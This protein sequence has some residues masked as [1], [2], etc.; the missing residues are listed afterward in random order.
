MRIKTLTVGL[1]ATLFLGVPALGGDLDPATEAA[2][3]PEA[4]FALCDALATRYAEACLQW[5][6]STESVRYLKSARGDDPWCVIH[7]VPCAPSPADPLQ[8][9]TTTATLYRVEGSAEHDLAALCADINCNPVDVCAAAPTLCDIAG[10]AISLDYQDP[11]PLALHGPA[12]ADIDH[13]G[14]IDGVAIKDATG[15]LY[16]DTTCRGYTLGINCVTTATAE[17]RPLGSYVKEATCTPSGEDYW[18]DHCSKFHGHTERITT[19][20]VSTTIPAS[21]PACSVNDPVGCANAYVGMVTGL[22]RTTTRDATVYVYE[23][24]GELDGAEMHDDLCQVKCVHPF[25][26]LQE[27][28]EAVPERYVP[29]LDCT[30][31]IIASTIYMP[32]PGWHAEATVGLVDLDNDGWSDGIGVYDAI[33]HQEVWTLGTDSISPGIGDAIISAIDTPAPSWHFLPT[34]CLKIHPENFE[35]RINWSCSFSIP[36]A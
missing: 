26:L 22:H 6:A 5:Q 3:S 8:Y 13:D 27:A 18:V 36:A 4:R 23:S 17:A 2:T 1:L 11:F 21:A 15:W 35:V 32:P 30:L 33:R 20:G 9:E 24:D 10:D 29:H 14:R 34:P 25:V 7:P 19:H 16:I 31:Y 28:C 12:L